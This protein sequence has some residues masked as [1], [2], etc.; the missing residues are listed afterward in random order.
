MALRNRI[1][2]RL[3]P[4]NPLY[5]LHMLMPSRRSSRKVSIPGLRHSFV[6]RHSSFVIVAGFL[7]SL[8]ASV[9][10]ATATIVSVAPSADTYMSMRAPDSNFGGDF[11]NVSGALGPMSGHD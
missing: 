3:D 8:I 11:S 10:P 5:W 2:L 1:P 7:F 4:M 9:V 6:V